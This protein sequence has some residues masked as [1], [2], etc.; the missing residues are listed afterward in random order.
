M[1]R[2]V[3]TARIAELSAQRT[4]PAGIP[5]N[6]LILEHDSEQAEAGQM[7]KVQLTIKAIVIGAV[8][9]TLRKHPLGS[10]HQFNGFL[11]NTKNGKGQLLHIQSFEPIT[12]I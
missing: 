2:V 12:I 6:D 9:E 11:S 7:R 10:T 4:T 8:A 3:L 1:N 5:A